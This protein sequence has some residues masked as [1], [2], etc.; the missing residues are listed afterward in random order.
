MEKTALQRLVRAFI[1]TSWF[2][3]LACG[4]A[5]AAS[6]R[7]NALDR[8]IDALS[9][10]DLATKPAT[11]LVDPDRQL[12]AQRLVRWRLPG[13]FATVIAQILV[14]AYFW[15]SGAAARLRDRL[16]SVTRNEALTRFAFGAALGLLSNLTAF[17]PEFYLYRI[18]RIMGLNDLLAR[19]WGGDWLLNTLASMAITGLVVVIVLA[20]VD[21][22][23]QWYIYTV[24]AIVAASLVVTFAAPY[25]N[26]QFA[27]SAE[28]PAPLAS[29]VRSL[30]VSMHTGDVPVHVEQATRSHVGDAA[31][32]GLGPSARIVISSALVAA[33][34]AEEVR[35]VVARELAHLDRR[36][37]LRIALFEALF[38]ILGA[39]LSVFVADR[40][41]FR[42]DDDEVS[43]L[44]LVAA[45]LGCVYLAAAPGLNAILRHM[46]ERAD[47]QAVAITG[48]RANA[49]R[50]LV[51]GAD[52]RMEEVC[53]DVMTSLYLESYPGM[54]DRIAS[55]NGASSGCP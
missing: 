2:V 27:R 10:H 5:H 28:L 54:G 9:T 21:R 17:I 41:G 46:T 19:A 43:R 32:V 29:T 1:A 50:A 13:W 37:P 6:Q 23:H 11:A 18:D 12:A 15:Q 48:D 51:R 24:L 40:I 55:I 7:P 26:V 52:Q 39:A 20:L 35:Y 8:R 49:V 3:V 22:T 25:L 31:V 4:I 16:R 14:L 34:T 42:R 53:P 45:L 47:A 38:V 33:A 36:D 30:E 44:A